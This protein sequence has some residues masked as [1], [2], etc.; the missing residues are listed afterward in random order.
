MWRVAACAREELLS[1]C[2]KR[3]GFNRAQHDFACLICMK[4]AMCTRKRATMEN[5]TCLVPSPRLAKE[6]CYNKECCTVAT[7]G[8]TS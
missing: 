4:V 5:C 3:D 7:E 2:P 1:I 6:S 8:K